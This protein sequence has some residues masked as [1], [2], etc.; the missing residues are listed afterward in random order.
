MLLPVKNMS[1]SGSEISSSFNEIAFTF[2][3]TIFILDFGH[4]EL[5]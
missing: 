2:S 4:K 5:R 1:N 3:F